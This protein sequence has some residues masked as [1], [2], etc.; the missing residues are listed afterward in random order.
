MRLL[1]GFLMLSLGLLSG[2]DNYGLVG[3]TGKSGAKDGGSELRA[4][5]PR[6]NL[7][8]QVY[9]AAGVALDSDIN[10]NSQGCI[11]NND[12]ENAQKLTQVS[13]VQGFASKVPTNGSE[14]NECFATSSD[15]DDFFKVSLKANQTVRLQVID[16]SAANNLDLLVF[17]ANN[18]QV[19]APQKQGLDGQIES[20]VIASDGDYFINVHAVSGGS[21]Y[22]LNI[23]DHI[24]ANAAPMVELVPGEAV[25]QYKTRSFAMARGAAVEPMPQ[26]LQLGSAA[27]QARGIQTFSAAPQDDFSELYQRRQTLLDIAALRQDDQVEYAEPNL[28]R[29]I[30]ATP[31]YSRYQSQWNYQAINLEQAWDISTGSEH[32][33]VVAVIDTGVYLD[34]EDLKNKLVA[35]YDFISN[36]SAARDGDGIDNNPDDPGDSDSVGASSWHGTHVAGIIAAETNNGLG[37]AGVGWNAKV[38]PVRVLGKGGGTSYDIAQGIRYA[39]GLSNNSGTVVAQKADIINLSL[40]SAGSAQAE[41]DA[42]AAAIYAGVIVVA[43][44]G[45][46]NVSNAYYP[47]AYSGVIAVAATDFLGYKASYSNYGTYISLA[48]PGGEMSSDANRDGQPD[49]IMSTY[50]NESSNRVRSSSYR[51]LQ[52]TSMA[53]P[54]VAGVLALMKAVN[55]NLTP[56]QVNHLIQTCA[57]T[58]RTPCTRNDQNGYG[59][60]DAYR[61]VQTAVNI[62]ENG[63]TNLSPASLSVSQSTIQLTS[64]QPTL[65]LTIANT[66]E[67]AAIS[68][69]ADPV[70][71]WLTIEGLPSTLEPGL[72]QT[73]QLKATTTSDLGDGLHTAK[74]NIRYKSNSNEA[75][76]S[77]LLNVNLWVGNAQSAQAQAPLY[78]I[79]EKADCDNNTAPAGC[80]LDSVAAD[81]FGQYQFS[82]KQAGR[83]RIFAGSDI[84]A[85]GLICEKGEWCGAY[86]LYSAEEIIELD[87]NRTQLNFTVDLKD[88]N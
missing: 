72:A 70:A 12:W 42:I 44:A 87:R 86:P 51:W 36:S 83:Y 2:C 20:V 37:V 88:A 21:K 46:S 55:P 59:L 22:L 52:G 32:Q 27:V 47:A 58:T 56:Q 28:I 73:I 69:Q 23:T 30:Q 1:S 16:A 64:S 15:P 45:N 14:A 10:D 7:S 11:S 78:V 66:G 61:A 17:S 67:V 31:N 40:G 54:H 18:E 19:G 41:R 79:L 82:N 29:R 57:L 48:A 75:S 24:E 33:V 63:G 76:L 25:V 8:G 77:L 34:H 85:N 26:L 80:V 50:V 68:V 49:G 4:V 65:E 84:D 39:A 5:T 6:F 62:A 35:G 38:M 9:Q 13:Y 53:S 74:L 3:Q 43:A 60:I 81:S 71:S